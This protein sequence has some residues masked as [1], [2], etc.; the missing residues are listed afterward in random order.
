[1]CSLFGSFDPGKPPF[2]SINNKQ[3]S[4]DKQSFK[5]NYSLGPELRPIAILKTL[6]S[7]HLFKIG[8]KV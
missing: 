2:F 8:Q 1:M 7:L 4:L 3:T 6:S 5:I